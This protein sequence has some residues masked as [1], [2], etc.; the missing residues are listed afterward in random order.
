[1]T[2]SN[3]SPLKNSVILEGEVRDQRPG[4]TKNKEMQTCYLNLFHEEENISPLG[5][6]YTAR[7]SIQVRTFGALAQQLNAANHIGCF[8]EVEGQLRKD[9]KDDK[10][11]YYILANTI[12][13]TSESA[14]LHGSKTK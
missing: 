6:Y 10:I 9:V 5:N 11:N 3:N 13:V 12:V 7:V 14:L 4:H 8:V 1:M 2:D